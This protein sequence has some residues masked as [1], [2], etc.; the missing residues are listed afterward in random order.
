M[1]FSAPSRPVG[2]LVKQG[3][4]L[5]AALSYHKLTAAPSGNPAG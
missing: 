3:E 1:A 4:I 2:R 5:Y